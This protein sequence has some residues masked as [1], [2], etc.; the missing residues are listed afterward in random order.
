[1]FSSVEFVRAICKEQGITVCQLEKD[2]GFSNGYLNPKK[3]S[4]LPYDRAL[5]IAEYL[6]ISV[7]MVLTGHE[8]MPKPPR[9]PDI[10]DRVDV[11]FYGEYKTLT[12]DDQAVIRDMVHIMRQRRQQRTEEEE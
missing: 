5:K 11:A 12:K 4:K 3:L 9:Q 8:H 6:D 7:E 2:C 10:L 1:M